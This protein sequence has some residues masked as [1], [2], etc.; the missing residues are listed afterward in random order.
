MYTKVKRCPAGH[1]SVSKNLLLDIDCIH[2][3]ITTRD[4]VQFSDQFYAHHIL[5]P[6]TSK[7][8][9]ELC[10]ED[11]DQ[12]N[13]ITKYSPFLVLGATQTQDPAGKGG[14]SYTHFPYNLRFDDAHY[15]LQAKIFSTADSGAHFYTVATVEHNDSYFL[16]Q[17]DNLQKQVQIVQDKVTSEFPP[18]DLCHSDKTVVACYKLASVNDRN[19]KYLRILRKHANG[20]SRPLGSYQQQNQ[21][22]QLFCYT[23]R[24]EYVYRA[25][26]TEEFY[27]LSIDFVALPK[28]IHNFKSQLEDI[29]YGRRP[30]FYKDL[31]IKS[32]KKNGAQ[33]AQNIGVMLGRVSELRPGYY[34]SRGSVVITETLADMFMEKL[35]QD[36]NIERLRLTYMSYIQ[37][38][39]A[40]ETAILLIAEDLEEGRRSKNLNEWDLM[41]IE[42]VEDL[43][44]YARLRMWKS[45][46]FGSIVF[47]E[48]YK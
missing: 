44:S 33:N 1:E 45:A 4:P 20:G 14:L 28:R 10:N 16:A 35:D 11:A 5:A 48:T 7:C 43:T 25:I 30:S 32:I 26:A 9:H 12:H 23:H 38:I 31:T 15:V 47:P 19:Y 2:E 40:P 24:I 6:T 29:L 34:G 18:E 42:G 3:C 17:I 41:Q 22:Q 36:H 13:A 21:E 27:P 46:Q 8:A 39:L 37:M